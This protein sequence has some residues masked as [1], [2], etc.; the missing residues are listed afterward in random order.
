LV[1]IE[2]R[3]LRGVVGAGVLVVGLLVGLA[4]TA[5]A[6]DSPEALIKQGVEM[7]RQGDDAKAHGYF[8]RAYELSQ[9]P[10][11][12]AQLGLVEQ[13]LSYFLDAQGHLAEA[14]A[15]DDAWVAQHRKVL[16]T[17]LTT[18]RGHLGQITVRGAPA[19]TTVEVGGRAAVALASGGIVWVNPGTTAL[20]F[21]AAEH[22]PAARN[23]TVAA[24][25]SIEL[26]VELPAVARPVAAAPS[27]AEPVAATAAA[28]VQKA[29]PPA[30]GEDHGRALRVAGLTTAGAGLGIGVAGAVIYSIGRSKL[31]AINSDATAGKP[32]NESNGNYQTYGDLGLGLMIGGGAA[33]VT[34]GLLYLLNGHSAE[35]GPAVSVSYLPGRGGV[36]QAG[37]CF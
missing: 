11:A 37:G 12:A 5:R 10:R 31:D 34:G 24:G 17:S 20:V 22:E 18:V 3:C 13:A 9:T 33:L 27:A 4:G 36:I 2:V 23:A 1:A 30:A 8:K 14:L 21:N 26:D 15:S 32:Y 25:A 6:E 16:E 35:S 7:R 29:G 19:G 28:T